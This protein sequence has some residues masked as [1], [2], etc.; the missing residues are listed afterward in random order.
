[1]LKAPPP[2]GGGVGERD[3]VGIN[4][5][6]NSVEVLITHTLH[7]HPLPQPLSRNAGEGSVRKF[8]KPVG[9]ALPTIVSMISTVFN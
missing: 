7:N 4:K 6:S 1:M 8:E 5:L 2:S 9:W 3:D